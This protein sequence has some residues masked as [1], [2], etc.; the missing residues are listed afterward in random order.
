MLVEREAWLN[1]QLEEANKESRELH[2]D[3][4][5]TMKDLGGCKVLLSQF[6]LTINET[7]LGL[8]SL[9]SPFHQ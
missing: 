2:D 9:I 1:A 3:V 5:T 8:L 6:S 7:W 4:V